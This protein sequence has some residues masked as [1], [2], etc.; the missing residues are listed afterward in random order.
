MNVRLI[1]IPPDAEFLISFCARVS[2]PKNQNSTKIA[3]LLKYCI[4]NKHWSIFEMSNMI[5][6]I[7][8]PKPIATQILRHRSFCFQQFSER[9]ANITNEFNNIPIPELRTQD[10]K[11]RQNSFSDKLDENLKNE[12]NEKIETHF[13]DAIEL[14][15][16]LIT[17]G[18]AKESARFI[19]PQNTMTRMYM[20]GNVRN[21]IHYII[22]RTDPSTQKEHREIALKIKE[23]FKLNLPIIAEALEW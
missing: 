18:I 3:N 22:T 2:N 6:E 4:K 15:N 14:Y 21:W 8:C 5:I 7:E 1:S 11:N 9:Y 20:S 17:N 19:M 10:H 13:N 16:E 12:L 23:I